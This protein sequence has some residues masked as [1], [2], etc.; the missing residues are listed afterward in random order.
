MQHNDI[1]INHYLTSANAA[2]Y[3]ELIDVAISG[4]TKAIALY[5][6]SQ[7]STVG[8]VSVYYKRAMV[9]I[10]QQEYMNA[11]SDLMMVIALDPHYA[12]AYIVRAHLYYCFGQF[13]M[14]I[15]DLTKAIT[16]N[17]IGQNAFDATL[18]NNRG[19][20][21]YHIG[22][23]KQSINDLS[24]AIALDPTDP[25]FY[26]SRGNVYYLM[27]DYKNMFADYK[28]VLTFYP[29]G[30]LT[31]NTPDDLLD[32]KSILKKVRD[33]LRAKKISVTSN[34]IFRSHGR[35]RNNGYSPEQSIRRN[36]YYKQDR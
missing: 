1:M 8:L 17:P 10:F 9:Y 11:W 5:F 20:A 32:M 7:K 25:T 35:R 31:H 30:V 3:F 34:S 14:M 2:A 15:R 28:K 24:K 22:N 4:Y 36:D 12:T 6:E 33:S 26:I 29:E 18:Y 23:Y 27:S 13:E 21:Y 16:L 19:M